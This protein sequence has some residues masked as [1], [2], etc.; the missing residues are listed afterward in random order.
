MYLAAAAPS[1]ATTPAEPTLA[2]VR[3]TVRFQEALVAAAVVAVRAEDGEWEPAKVTLQDDPTAPNA[4]AV[5][6]L[7]PGA[8]PVL[9]ARILALSNGGAAAERIASFLSE[10]VGP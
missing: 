6:D 4:I 3:Q 10:S 2:E 8:V 1:P 5:R 7:P 9:A